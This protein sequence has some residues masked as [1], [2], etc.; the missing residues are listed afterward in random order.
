VDAWLDRYRRF[1]NGGFDRLDGYLAELKAGQPDT[2]L[3]EG[4][5]D[6]A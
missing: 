6:A 2:D 5:D 1:W 3:R 4:D